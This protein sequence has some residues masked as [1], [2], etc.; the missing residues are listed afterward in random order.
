MS[1]VIYPSDIG[2]APAPEHGNKTTEKEREEQQKALDYRADRYRVYEGA[3]GVARMRAERLR[4]ELYD[5]PPAIYPSS[6]HSN[7]AFT[8][9]ILFDIEDY[10]TFGTAWSVPFLRSAGLETKGG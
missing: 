4:E 2:K 3:I 9:R 1:F 7:A 5:L 8:A 6:Y 10:S